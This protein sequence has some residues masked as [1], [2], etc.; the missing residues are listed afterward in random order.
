MVSALLKVPVPSSFSKTF[1][2]IQNFFINIYFYKN[3][4]IL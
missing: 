1:L 2:E 3:A 4:Y